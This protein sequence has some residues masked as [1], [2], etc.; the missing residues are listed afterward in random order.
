MRQ[1]FI[2]FFRDAATEAKGG[3][4]PEEKTELKSALTEVQTALESKSKV[5]ID[6]ALKLHLKTINEANDAFKKWQ[7]EKDEADK[8]N[9]EAIDKLLTD[10]KELNKS[11]KTN[12]DQKAKSLGDA[13]A[14][15]FADKAVFDA[16]KNVKRGN[17]LNIKLDGKI[18]LSLK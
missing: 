4:T 8:K 15:K 2:V 1:Y 3:F 17:P 14:E 13:L 9:Q 7:G 6:E 18:D 5:F 11:V 10:I 12:A 16:L